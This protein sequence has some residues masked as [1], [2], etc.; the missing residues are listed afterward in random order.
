MALL[1]GKTRIRRAI[2][3]MMCMLMLCTVVNLPTLHRAEAA[4]NE[5][6]VFRSPGVTAAASGF[7]AADSPDR[8][9]DGSAGEGSKWSYDAGLS[10]PSADHPYWLTVDVGAQA[11]VDRFV[12][13]HA[14]AG[15]E[16]PDHNTRDFTIEVSD[17]EIYWSTVVTVTGSVY[18]TTVHTLDEP[19]TA[20]YFKL[21]ITDPGVQDAEDGTYAA[22][23]Y[24]FQAYGQ[25]EASNI[26]PERAA[27]F[28]AEALAPNM[29]LISRD[30]EWNYLD[31]GSDQGT[32]WRD[33]YFDDRAWKTGQAP[34]GYAGSG[35]GQDV[36]TWIEYGGDSGNKHI[37]SYFRQTFQADDA[38][39][40]KKLTAT[41]IRDD[42]AVI[43]LNGAEVYRAN[44]PEGTVTYQTLASGAVGDERIPETFDI[45]PS[46][47]RD[48]TNV[49]AAEVH[50][51]ARSSSDLF[52]SLE[53]TASDEEPAKN[54]GLLAQYYTNSGD[55]P[56]SIVDWKATVIDPNIDFSNLDPVL[57][58]RV[59]RSDDAN[60]TWTGQIR[61]EYSEDYTFYMIG[62]NGF[63]LWIDGELVIDHW[64]NDWDK[65]QTSSP[66]RLE[67]GQLYDIRI[68]YFED[69]GGSNLFLRW[70]SDSVPK[71][72]VPASALFLPADYTGPL[73]GTLNAS[74]DAAELRFAEEL[75]SL[76]PNFPDG[77][78]VRVGDEVRPVQ[79]AEL[80]GSDASTIRLQLDEPIAPKER[81]SVE[82]DGTA[83]LSTASGGTIGA[84]AFTLKNES[85]WVDYS[86]IAIAMSLYGSAKTNRS[87]AWYTSYEHPKNAPAGA[88]DSIVEVVRADRSF[89]SGDALRFEGDS[90]IINVK[91]MNSTNGAF[92]SHKVLVEG[93]EPGTS[94]K[95]RVGSENNWSDVGTFTTEAADEREYEFL[96]MTDSQGANTQ[97][98]EV[99]ADTL[100]QGLE[101]YPASKFLVMAGD[102][103]DAGPIES[104]WLD[105]FG[106]P[107]DMLMHLPLM[108]AVGNHEGPYNDNFF[109]HFHY[110]NDA[111]D[112][113]LPRGSVY[114]FDYG[115]ARFMVMN[116]MDMGWDDRQKESFKQQ[117]EWLRREVAE[118][119]K[120]WKIAVIHKAIYS[121]GGHSADGDILELRDK[122]YPVFDELGIDLVLQGHD[123]TYMR[124][125]QMYGDKPVTDLEKDE[126]GAVV[127]PPGT[128]YIVNNSAGRKY[129]GVRPEVDKYYADVY[130]QPNRPIYSGIRMTADSLTIE[131]YRSGEDQP[132]D[133]YTIVRT[134]G[135]PAP[136]QHLA[137]G[138]TGSGEVV[139]SWSMPEQAGTEDR[140]RGFRIYE[141]NGRLGK[142]WS[143]YVPAEDGK[144]DYR[145]VVEAADSSQPYVFAV[146]AADERDNSLPVTVSTDTNVPAAPTDPVEDDGH[147]TFGWTNVPGYDDAADY[148]Y[149]VDGGATWHPVSANPQPVGDAA[150]AAGAV[151]VR[152]KADDAAGISAGLPLLSTRPFTVNSI[153]DTFKLAGSMTRDGQLAVDVS[154]EQTAK[155]EGDAYLVFEL[156]DGNTPLL[157]NA[158][159][160]RQQSMRIPQYFNVHGP[161]Y[162]VKVFVFDAFDSELD[163]PVH[164]AAPIELQ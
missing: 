24:E 45:D 42:G 147:N 37:T 164:L 8:A 90:E 65:E 74:G 162:R 135:R 132:F 134:D 29:E 30:S 41:L 44:M 94:Y 10:A 48:G 39:S 28:E 115:D 77:L 58:E 93:L 161:N 141:E 82:Y 102:Q 18:D 99:W 156:L 87:F 116:T 105:Y 125:Y 60:V 34:L 84:F 128:M 27:A 12:L 139:L 152:V 75:A 69:Y 133:A 123:H 52:F 85:E 76:P 101:K 62:D 80:D 103:V 57:Q 54:Q 98:Y 110:P 127:N 124:S 106:K 40:V 97:D 55:M 19:V 119:D 9:I 149:S 122:L 15:G 72:I 136:V 107:Q 47:L 35:K 126:H 89:E 53:L 25:T 118:T 5:S 56:F 146:K 16:S 108:A 64:V 59:G 120:K 32:V 91:I 114:A 96:Y 88:E 11:T 20:R 143:V 95:Y 130:E 14:G 46:L 117:I 22:T 79:A 92:I 31:D 78:K 113:P 50:Q 111:I 21:N 7:D 13:M 71:T 150:Y 23:I 51:N 67:A 63:K 3:V 17:D 49:V 61:P 66:V 112:D 148:E 43:Y 160:I 129:Y 33:V 100:R 131:S 155:Y 154:V 157:I 121:V 104:Q 73:A 137:A 144:T 68:E 145:Y 1:W 163:A 140:I 4:P 158:I 81:V 153:H 38:E 142:N 159:P 70:S 151:Q 36:K 86:P 26:I 138:A 83:A 109:Y 2:A 6:N